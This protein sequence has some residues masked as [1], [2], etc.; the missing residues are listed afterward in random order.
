VTLLSISI[1]LT[2][3]NVRKQGLKFAGHMSLW[4]RIFSLPVFIIAPFVLHRMTMASHEEL[5]GVRV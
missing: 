5:F 1:V 2:C 3:G 4:L